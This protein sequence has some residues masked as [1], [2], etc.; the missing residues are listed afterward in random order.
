MII[1]AETYDLLPRLFPYLTP[2]R[3]A[4]EDGVG[5]GYSHLHL[6]VEKTNSVG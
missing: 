2:F 6:A 5:R 3:P 1:M 4:K